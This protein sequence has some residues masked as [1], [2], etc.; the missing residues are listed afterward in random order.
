MGSANTMG[1][2]NSPG[3]KEYEMLKA[4]EKTGVFHEPEVETGS[5]VRKRKLEWIIVFGILILV[6][7]IVVILNDPKKPRTEES[8]VYTN[9]SAE[10]FYKWID[11]PEDKVL[12][13]LKKCGVTVTVDESM[14]DAVRTTYTLRGGIFDPSA[15]ARIIFSQYGKSKKMRLSTYVEDLQDS[16]WPEATSSTGMRVNNAYKNMVWRFGDISYASN[17]LGTNGKITDYPGD[18][19]FDWYM[20]DLKINARLEVIY[21]EGVSNAFQAYA[22]Y[23]SLAAYEKY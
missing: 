22:T 12:E 20:T 10:E 13:Y 15:R 16:S 19:E 1:G 7:A 6:A 2:P 17:P 3:F 18:Y 4:A 14:T 5:A 8:Y 23:D 9:Q 11:Q 21:H